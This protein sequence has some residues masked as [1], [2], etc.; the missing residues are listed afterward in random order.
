MTVMMTVTEKMKMMTVK[1]CSSLLIKGQS[2]NNYLVESI[3]Y[4][5][6]SIQ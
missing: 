3:G 1:M 2:V 5:R 6:Y 4:S